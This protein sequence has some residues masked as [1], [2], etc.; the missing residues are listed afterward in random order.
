M[1][2]IVELLICDE[3]ILWNY[4]FVMK[5]VLELVICDENL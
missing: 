2:P 5:P 3:N 4:L 1:K